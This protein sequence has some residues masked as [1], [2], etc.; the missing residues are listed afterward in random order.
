MTQATEIHAR[1]EGLQ[2]PP[3]FLWGAATAAYQI[4]GA[5][6]EDGRG[7]SIWDTFSHTEG[8]VE[9][10]ENGDVAC[11]HYH[12]FRDDVA[13]M[14]DLGLNAYRFSISWSRVQPTGSGRVNQAGIDFYSQL[15]DSLLERGITPAPTLFHW[16]LPQGLEDTGGWLNRDTSQRFADYAGIMANVLGDR[17][18]MWITLN[19]AFVH[20]TLGHATGE[21][22]P[23]H[24]LLAGSFAVT[25]HLLVGHG[26]AV[27]ALRSTLPA[28]AMVGITNNVATARPATDSEADRVAAEAFEVLQVDTYNDPIFR[29]SYPEL[30][31]VLPGIDMSV[32]ADG[33]LA[34]TSE[35]L[36]FIGINYYAPSYIA[37]APPDLPL[38]FLPSVPEGDELTEM[39]WP[40]VPEGFTEVLVGMK[41]RYGDT[42]PPIYITENGA[43]YPDEVGEDG[44]IDDGQRIEYIESHLRAVRAAMD[45]G[46]DIRGYFVWSL[47]DNFEW[48]YGYRPRFGLVRVDFDTMARTPKRSAYWYRDLIRAQ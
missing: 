45:A 34:I 21:H 38:P 46:V 7:P 35:P 13:L 1:A 3:G 26:L 47:L 27:Q 6:N 32:V 5:A 18:P 22:A 4:E 11:D 43:A 33:D 23:G 29:S 8:K 36:D 31:A 15:V 48:A 42:L 10:G 40:V 41:A 20:A 12:R 28:G 14:A 30:S 9:R 37:A 39:G 25:H 17:V 44:A 24:M 16:D 2:F 19:E